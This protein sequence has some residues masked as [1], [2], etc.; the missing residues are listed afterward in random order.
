MVPLEITLVPL[1]SAR[2]FVI[3][4]P[5]LPLTQVNYESWLLAKEKP[6]FPATQ[7]VDAMTFPTPRFAQ[8]LEIPT[9]QFV[10]ATVTSTPQNVQATYIEGQITKTIPLT[11]KT[12]IQNTIEQG[13]QLQE[14][15]SAA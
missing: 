11:T 13:N 9:S 12:F 4:N 15:R 7:K 2:S 8:S 1:E 5:D 10:K 6:T 14:W 3:D